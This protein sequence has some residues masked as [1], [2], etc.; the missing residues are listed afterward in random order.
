VDLVRRQGAA[1]PGDG[2]LAS[3]VPL[4]RPVW[5]HKE[6]E[7][8]L[9]LPTALWIL[10]AV[11][12]VRLWL[13]PLGNSFW[14][15]E[16]LTMWM[17]HNGP[18][19]IPAHQ[20][21]VFAS[22][23][24]LTS[25]VLGTNEWAMRVPSIIAALLSIF[26]FFRLGVEILDRETGVICAAIFLANPQMN[27]LIPDARPYA[28]AMLM[29]TAAV[30]F[31]FR[32][33]RTK[34]LR[35]GI[36][37]VACGALACHLHQL[38]LIALPIE[39]GLALW[40]FRREMR[41]RRGLSA[42]VAVAALGALLVAPVIHTMWMLSADA[43]QLASAGLPSWK[44]FLQ[45]LLPAYVLLSV[46]LVAVLEWTSGHVTW[47]PPKFPPQTLLFATILFLA[48]HIL[49]YGVTRL[50]WTQLYASRFLLLALPGVVILGS[51][52]VRG[53][54]PARVRYFMLSGMLGIAIL[55]VGGFRLVPDYRQEGW[56]TMVRS[57]P[58]SSGILLY[59]G[60]IE[61]RN[62][63][64]MRKPENW[65]YL[66]APVLTYRPHLGPEDVGLVPYQFDQGGRDYVQRI[67]SGPFQDRT[68]LSLIA[69]S[70]P[71]TDGP[72]WVDWIAQRLH[73]FGFEES[74]SSN[75]GYVI[76]RVF[77]A[78]QTAR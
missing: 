76:V 1:S 17:I 37:W 56:R 62:A 26:V 35:E 27:F 23:E 4:S 32:W 19:A 20:S 38:F 15:D 68:T 31:L 33:L 28:L 72:Q 74:Q 78:R 40:H 47:R 7:S 14:L 75:D 50:G 73:E 77:Q 48:P 11:V 36:L 51:L 29:H 2:P 3:A 8:G 42:G 69:R 41:T 52:L 45:E 53:F 43:R 67:L 18:S 13:L 34:R 60:L 65:A 63:A 6:Q 58:E 61:T 12:I 30:F 16:T 70:F 64:W 5:V 21:T 55:W 10:A 71:D 25:V 66:T 39:S 46:A 54:Q 49:L 9:R 24:W 22:I 57:L 59:S 44:D